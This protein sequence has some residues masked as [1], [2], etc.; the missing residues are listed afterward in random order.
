MSRRCQDAN[1]N[2]KAGKTLRVQ[3]VGGK[4]IRKL[5][6]LR[7]SFRKKITEF[8][9]EIGMQNAK[10]KREGG[11]KVHVCARISRRYTK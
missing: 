7:T 11:Q 2:R 5:F 9:F 1:C 10:C 4:A 8:V 6:D 3:S